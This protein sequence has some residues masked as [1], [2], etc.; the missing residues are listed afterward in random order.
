[1]NTTTVIGILGALAL[2]GGIAWAGRNS[3]TNN[4]SSEAPQ[5]GGALVGSE[6]AFDF[7]AV[8]M[9]AGTV[10]HAFAIKNTG[11]APVKISTVYTSCMC[12]SAKLTINGQTLGPYGMP[13]HGPL[14]RINE[15]LE[16][17]AEA[18]VEAEF[19]PA[20]HGPAG[21]GR[22]QRTIT[23]EHDAGQALE[24]GFAAQVTP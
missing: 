10:K 15:I 13:G 1:M 17:G 18:T 21:V 11:T 16:A 20:A 2:L 24:L 8:S 23:I 9:A 5:A 22:I 7:G 3:P 6:T 19:D 4:T 12:T 14:P